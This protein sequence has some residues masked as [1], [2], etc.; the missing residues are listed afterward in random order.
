MNVPLLHPDIMVFYAAKNLAKHDNLEEFCPSAVTMLQAYD[1][2]HNTP[3]LETLE[4]YLLYVGNPVTAAKALNIH[5]N[6]L[7]YRVNK[8]KELTQV[9]LDNG[10]ER[11]K[12]QLYLKFL[13]Y[14]KGGW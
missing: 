10:K 6:T 14:Q 11:L 3:L 7:L 9:D 2:K 5:R 12:I 13:E 8:I 4:K 1:A